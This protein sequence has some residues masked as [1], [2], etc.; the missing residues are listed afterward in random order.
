MKL[1]SPFI[2]TVIIGSLAV[3]AIGEYVCVKNQSFGF[4]GII[5]LTG[6][7]SAYFAV[8]KLGGE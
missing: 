6:A 5:A 7:A 1:G 3:M 8:C 2:W 4:A